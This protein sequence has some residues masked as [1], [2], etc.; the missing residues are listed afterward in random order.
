VRI[1]RQCSSAS[2]PG[3]TSPDPKQSENLQR[4]FRASL[5][6]PACRRRSSDWMVSTAF[7][8]RLVVSGALLLAAAFSLR[9]FE[10]P[11]AAWSAAGAD[12]SPRWDIGALTLA[13]SVVPTVL[14]ILALSL[15]SVAL[16]GRSSRSLPWIPFFWAAVSLG[17]ACLGR[18]ELKSW[19]AANLPAPL[20]RLWVD[21]SAGQV[22]ALAHG[23]GARQVVAALAG[24][25][26]AG[27]ALRAVVRHS[28]PETHRRPARGRA[29]RGGVPAADR[30]SFAT[31][32]DL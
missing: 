31:W 6:L 7:R 25:A 19:A 14:Q 18:P 9:F 5:R 8:R 16:V 27:L 2:S 15:A 26:V 21:L 24:V 1:R 28:G 23:F 10:S 13:L 4:S 29:G 22:S 12:G 32:G 11:L 20:W 30:G 3:A 17:L